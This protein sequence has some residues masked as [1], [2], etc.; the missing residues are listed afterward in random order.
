M[1]TQI[2]NV[3]WNGMSMNGMEFT[4]YRGLDIDE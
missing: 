2:T 4:I 3:K 1:H